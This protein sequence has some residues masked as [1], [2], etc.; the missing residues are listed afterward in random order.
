[1]SSYTRTKL[2]VHEGLFLKNVQSS[3]TEQCK[4]NKK[5]IYSWT[6]TIWNFIILQFFFSIVFSPAGPLISNFL[7]IKITYLRFSD[8][9][10]EHT[11]IRSS[12]DVAL[13]ANFTAIIHSRV[14]IFSSAK[15]IFGPFVRTKKSFHCKKF[16]IFARKLFAN[17]KCT[18]EFQPKPSRIQIKI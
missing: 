2:N 18:R 4:I 13:F 10:L 17:L 8:K 3:N 11:I 7:K 14:S 16:Q 15:S 1:M 6:R 9:Y 12:S 5:G